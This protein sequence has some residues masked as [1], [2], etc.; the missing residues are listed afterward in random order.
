MENLASDLI[1][2]LQ[3]L[4]PG[5]L[6]AWIFYGF[7]SYPLPSQFERIVQALILTLIVRA[8]VYCFEYFLVWLG[9]F[10]SI[11]VWNDQ[12][13]LI[14]S[15]IIAV[16]LGLVFSYFANT[17]KFHSFIRK[18]GIT[19]ETSFPSEWFG[20]FSK[21]ITYVILHL[22]DERRIYGWPVE[23]PS[24]PEKGH[25]SLVQTSWIID[26]K[27]VSIIG[28]ESILIAAT[29]VKWVEFMQKSWEQTNGQEDVESA[30]T[31]AGT[32]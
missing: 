3:Y 13:D 27:E 21:N 26:G 7:T 6:A 29:D 17:D 12:S 4:L 14:F 16:L 28:V 5:F 23:W 10:Y 20:E 24:S 15:T 19:K 9:I 11:G 8:C 1:L 2:L 25:F 30:T 18:F 22:N 32:R 31:T